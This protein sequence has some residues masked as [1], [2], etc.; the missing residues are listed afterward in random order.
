MGLVADGGEPI[1]VTGG[2]VSDNMFQALGAR[3]ALGRTIEPGDATLGAP[4]VAV[5]SD[6]LWRSA[7][8]RDPQRH[9][10]RHPA[11]RAAAHHRRR[12]AARIRDFRARPRSVD[13]AAVGSRATGITR[14]R[15]RSAWRGSR[16]GVTPEAASREAAS[17]SRRRCARTSAR[18]TTGDRRCACSRCRSRSP[19]TS[20]PRLADPARRRGPDSHARGR[21]PR[22]ARA[23]PIDR[24][25]RRDG[26]A[27]RPRRVAR[28][29]GPSDRDRAGGAGHR[30][31]PS[32]VSRVAYLAMPILIA[33]IPAEVPRL[34]EI[35][36]DWTVL[37]SVLAGSVSVAMIVALMPAVIT[38]RPSLQPLLRQSRTTD[39]PGAPPRARRAGGRADRPRR[40]ARASARC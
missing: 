4:A 8:Q 18:P 30:W 22:H 26:A 24:A 31:A 5:L 9:R 40:G 29:P 14:P 27:H 3:A 25:R 1:K 37:M 12:H 7:V 21:Q 35:T 39:T 28:A 11:R 20:G 23:R 36:L 32:P 34:S 6:E 38:A 16:R 33:R 13:G 15:S 19:A 10:P 2:R 17:I